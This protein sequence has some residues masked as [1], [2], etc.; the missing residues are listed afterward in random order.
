MSEKD[1][2]RLKIAI[3]NIDSRVSDADSETE[4][5]A[6][7]TKFAKCLIIARGK[8]LRKFVKKSKVIDRY[9]TVITLI[10]DDFKS[11]DPNKLKW[12][13]FRE[14]FIHRNIL[15]TIEFLIFFSTL[16]FPS[17]AFIDLSDVGSFAKFVAIVLF[18]IFSMACATLFEV[19]ESSYK[20]SYFGLGHRRDE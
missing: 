9:D 15:G 6:E 17:W 11:L 13:M 20:S 8:E 12:V 5:I 10:S 3:S 7:D 2:D 16:I 4:K 19:Y 18:F 1:F 14:G